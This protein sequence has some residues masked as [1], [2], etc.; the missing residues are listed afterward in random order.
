VL[1]KQNAHDKQTNIETISHSHWWDVLDGMCRM[2]WESFGSWF[3][4]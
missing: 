2:A 3:D 1:Y 4:V